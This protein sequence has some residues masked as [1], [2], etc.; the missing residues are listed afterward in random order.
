MNIN[1]YMG[2][3][4]TQQQLEI[5]EHASELI[6]NGVSEDDLYM[7]MF[8]PDNHPDSVNHIRGLFKANITASSAFTLSDLSKPITVIE[9]RVK[10]GFDEHRTKVIGKSYLKACR[11]MLINKTPLSAL[12]TTLDTEVNQSKRL[13]R[14]RS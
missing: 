9:K 5:N 7:V 1:E 12:R 14:S 2:C 11:E 10:D 4:T 6:S 3:L 8:Y 13:L